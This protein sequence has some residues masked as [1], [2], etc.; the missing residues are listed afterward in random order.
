MEDDENHTGSNRDH[1]KLYTTDRY[2]QL[3]SN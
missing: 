2:V 1:G 3:S